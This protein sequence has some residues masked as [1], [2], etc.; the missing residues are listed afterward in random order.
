[1]GAHTEWPSE[2]SAEER[3]NSYNVSICLVAERVEMDWRAVDAV[4]RRQRAVHADQGSRLVPPAFIRCAV[5]SQASSSQG[6]RRTSV[7]VERLLAGRS[8]Q[9]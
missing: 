9:W 5:E 3:Y 2:C 7:G 4:R 8:S 6:R 1:M